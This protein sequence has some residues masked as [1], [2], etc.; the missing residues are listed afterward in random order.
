MKYGSLDVALRKWGGP[1]L[2]RDI[3]D[4]GRITF[5]P[6]WNM[7]KERTARDRD[8]ARFLTEVQRDFYAQ[9]IQYLRQE[10]GFK[11]LITASNWVTASPQYLGPLEKYSYTVGD[12]IDRH[13]YFGCNAKGDNSGWSIRDGHSYADRSAYR[14]D[15]ETPGKPR[16]FS[17]PAMD[18]SYDGKPSML[19]EIAWNRPNR[20]RSE[21]PIYLAAYGAL[22]DTDA[23]VLF[24]MDGARWSTKPGYFMQ[25]WTIASPATMG[26][27]PAAALFYRKGLI[28]AGDLLVDLNLPIDDILDLRGTPLPQDAAFDELRLKD[29]PPLGVGETEIKPGNVL[30]PLVHYVGR[31][32]V[33]FTKNKTPSKI[34][35]FSRWI[36]RKNQQV[37]SSTGELILDYGKGLLKIDAPAVQGLSGTLAGAGTIRLKDLS[38]ASKME[39]G[40]IIAVSL[41]GAPLA[42]SK[43]ILLQVMSEEKTNGFA[44]E[45][46]GS[47]KRIIRIGGD[48][49]LVRE[50]EGVVRLH[51]PDAA[52][53]K[54]VALDQNG[55][56][57]RMIGTADSIVLE[58]RTI[59]YLVTF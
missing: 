30:D 2:K 35:D 43:K 10:L 14:F 29:V 52:K 20:Y 56:A 7:S 51:R 46:A 17:H 24:A 33:N 37:R 54:V 1:K 5:R 28:R 26:Q 3:P 42:T 34:Q 22:Q 45:L 12:F 25:P 4:E 40:H 38:I 50:F 55:Q 9:T 21:A 57:C 36:D 11:G 16:Q 59:Y 19:S 27:F 39:I 13:G 15:A 31:T 53:L 18:P 23:I 32:N 8:A 49:W 48:P 6:L 58:P 41:D 47:G 44:T